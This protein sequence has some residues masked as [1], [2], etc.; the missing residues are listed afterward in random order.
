MAFVQLWAVQAGQTSLW[1]LAPGVTA[2]PQSLVLR[3]QVRSA[4][5]WFLAAFFAYTAMPAAFTGLF[6]LSVLPAGT[7][8][9]VLPSAVLA[10]AA[11]SGVTGF[12]LTLLLRRARPT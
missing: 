8:G 6:I 5:N 2:L 7:L 9:S 12:G 11:S 1:W 4:F 3:K 10:T